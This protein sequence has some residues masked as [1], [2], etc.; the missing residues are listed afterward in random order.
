MICI[1]AAAACYDAGILVMSISPPSDPWH[2][3]TVVLIMRLMRVSITTSLDPTTP[4]QERLS[5]RKTLGTERHPNEFCN[6]L[7]KKLLSL[8]NYPRHTAVFLSSEIHS[9]PIRGDNM[10]QPNTPVMLLHAVVVKRNRETM[11][12]TSAPDKIVI[13]I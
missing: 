10:I 1:Y 2:L 13:R 6:L 5:F 12:A 7:Y 11:S 8:S 9:K 4:S 3:P